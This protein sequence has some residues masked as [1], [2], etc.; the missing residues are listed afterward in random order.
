VWETTAR[1]LAKSECKMI[2]ASIS[3]PLLAILSVLSFSLKF[4][5][6]LKKGGYY[7]IWRKEY[8]FSVNGKGTEKGEILET[9]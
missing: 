6:Y 2:L 9:N 7:N 5:T 8:D 4:K 3:I 1:Q